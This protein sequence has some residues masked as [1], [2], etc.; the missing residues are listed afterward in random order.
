MT[1]YWKITVGNSMTCTAAFLHVNCLNLLPAIG[2]RWTCGAKTDCGVRGSAR[3]GETLEL[4]SWTF[5]RFR[6]KESNEIVTKDRILF[7]SRKLN[8]YLVGRH[9]WQHGWYPNLS[10]SFT[11]EAW[12]RFCFDYAETS[13]ESIEFFVLPGDDTRLSDRREIARSWL[14]RRCYHAR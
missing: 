11:R 12:K 10:R 7:C 2:N 14:R 3:A 1:P 9:N 8:S 6:P 5:P 13:G 4:G